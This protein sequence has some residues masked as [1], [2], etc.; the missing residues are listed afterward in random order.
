MS[1]ET[2]RYDR[3]N[4]HRIQVRIPNELL[5]EIMKN[6]DED[7]LSQWV[8]DACKDRMLLQIAIKQPHAPPSD[9]PTHAL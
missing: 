8:I 2:K 3:K 5:D 1:T 6:L 4:S 7:T 9:S